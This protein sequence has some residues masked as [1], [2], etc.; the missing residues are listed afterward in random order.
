LITRRERCWITA[1]ALQRD[2]CRR[3]LRLAG[4]DTAILRFKPLPTPRGPPKPKGSK[5]FELP[6][7]RKWS[8]FRGPHSRHVSKPSSGSYETENPCA[9]SRLRRA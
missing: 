5:V 7:N 8:R 6:V 1:Q 4:R 2:H 9:W 3:L